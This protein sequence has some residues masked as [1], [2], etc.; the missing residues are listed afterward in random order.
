MRAQPSIADDD[1]TD[2]S[3]GIRRLC[4][5]DL[6]QYKRGQM[7]RRIRTFATTRGHKDLTAY[8][9]VLRGDKIELEGFLN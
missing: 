8:L 7:E 9:T 4:S 5:I 2:F 3:E 6:L 1:Y